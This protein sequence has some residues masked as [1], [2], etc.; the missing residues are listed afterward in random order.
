[1]AIVEASPLSAF[2]ALAD[3]P[4]R[5]RMIASINPLEPI[6]D[7]FAVLGISAPIVTRNSVT[8]Q[9]RISETFAPAIRDNTDTTT[10]IFQVL[11]PASLHVVIRDG[12]DTMD[13][14]P[15]KMTQPRLEVLL[16]LE[17]RERTLFIVDGMGDR[18]LK[19]TLLG[20]RYCRVQVEVCA[21][22]WFHEFSYIAVPSL[23][24]PEA[25]LSIEIGAAVMDE[26]G[27]LHSFVAAVD[28]ED[29]GIH[30]WRLVL[31]PAPILLKQIK[32]MLNIPEDMRE[33]CGL[34][35]LVPADFRSAESDGLLSRLPAIFSRVASLALG[36]FRYIPSSHETAA[37]EQL[38]KSENVEVIIFLRVP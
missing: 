5:T 28:V 25:E 26:T 37:L 8:Q 10:R 1:M 3:T 12:A 34:E 7:D 16:P 38:E 2:G 31:T 30:S 20:E 19:L 35:F 18:K 4:I 11:V 9:Y 13:L 27:R 29:D 24:L 33:S 14:K 21:L 32:C 23:T 17:E 15:I 6:G 22:Y 36:G